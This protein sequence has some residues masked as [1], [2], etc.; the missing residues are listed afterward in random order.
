VYKAGLWGKRLGKLRKLSFVK[1]AAR[2]DF[3]NWCFPRLAIHRL[4]AGRRPLQL[5]VL[6]IK[7]SLFA[8][9]FCVD[10][11][12]SKQWFAFYIKHIP[13]NIFARF[14]KMFGQ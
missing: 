10:L 5:S 12:A 2:L 7:A 13:I 11:N 6:L 4:T 9:E 14:M 1:A 3:R 8:N